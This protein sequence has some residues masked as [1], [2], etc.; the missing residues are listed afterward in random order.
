MQIRHA[1]I[2]DAQE[3]I[4]VMQDAESSNLMLFG[5]GERKVSKEPFTKFIE[6]IS[7]K[8]NSA[9]FVA[10]EQNQIVG[11]LIVQGDSPK[12]ISHRAYIVI[13]VHSNMRGKGVGKSLFVHVHKWAKSKGFHR[14]ELTVITQNTPAVNLYKKMGYAIEGVKH[15]SLLIDGEYVDEYYMAKLI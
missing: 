14:L 6:M 13:G 5:P 10:S 15:D 7:N 1:T 11:Y 3:I 9:L 4:Q 8:A 12:R 2:H